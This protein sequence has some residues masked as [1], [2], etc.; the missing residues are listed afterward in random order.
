MAAPSSTRLVFP[1]RL[2]QVPA[3]Q[4]AIVSAAEAVGFDEQAVFAIRLALDEALTNAVRHGNASDPNKQVT[5]EFAADS[6]KLVVQIE[7]QGPGFALEEV[8]DPTADENLCRPHGRGVMLMRA[9]MS[10]VQFNER[11]NRVTLTKLRD[12]AAP[13]RP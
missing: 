4:H 1:S 12:C 6:Q 13:Q 5:V 7:D 2:D 10:D 3:V 9:Y 11:G 8:P